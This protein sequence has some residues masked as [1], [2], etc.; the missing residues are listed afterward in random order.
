MSLATY[1]SGSETPGGQAFHLPKIVHPSTRVANPNSLNVTARA[2]SRASSLGD[3]VDKYN[4]PSEV[5]E[6]AFVKS[7]RLNTSN[8]NEQFDDFNS[9]SNSNINYNIPPGVK[10]VYTP[11]VNKVSMPIFGKLELIHS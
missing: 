10:A 2:V 7:K 11:D 5:A 4:K 1:R 6:S 3:L 9:A 8:N